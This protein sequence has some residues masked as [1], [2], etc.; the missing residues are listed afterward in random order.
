MVLIEWDDSHSHGSNE[1]APLDGIKLATH[2]LRCLDPHADCHQWDSQMR[3]CPVPC[4]GAG[5]FTALSPQSVAVGARYGILGYLPTDPMTE[6]SSTRND[7]TGEKARRSLDAG[8]ALADSGNFDSAASRLYYSL[9]QAAVTW[10]RK[11]NKKPSDYRQ[12]ANDQASW[13]HDTIV[14]NA[15]LYRKSSR[16]ANVFRRARS[17]RIQADYRRESVSPQLVRGIVEE[18]RELVEGILS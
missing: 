3:A 15:G 11:H 6:A 7:P 1:W 10:M 18:C 9:Y 4:H 17:Q 16:D 2:P 13:P 5:S 14:G 12:G 8:A